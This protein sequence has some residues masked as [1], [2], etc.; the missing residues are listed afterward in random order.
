[1]EVQKSQKGNYILCIVYVKKLC[2]YVIVHRLTTCYLP[3][4][5]I[6]TFLKHL[7]KGFIVLEISDHRRFS[8]YSLNKI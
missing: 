4:T 3:I 5:G 6:F 1:M 2:T 7:Q 8:G